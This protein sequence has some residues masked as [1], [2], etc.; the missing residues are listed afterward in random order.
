MKVLKNISVLKKAINNISSLGFVP[1]MGGLHKGHISLIKKSKKKCKKTIVSIYINPKQFDNKNDFSNY[2]RDLSKDLNLLK[3]INPDYV[4]LPTTKEMY[5]SNSNKKITLLKSEKIL[6]AK[7][8][9]G[10]FEGVLNIMD[11]FI[12]LI[13]PKYIFMGEKDFQQLYLIK[14]FIKNKY[15]S[16]IYSCKTIRDKNYI[17]LST[18]NFLL[19]KKDLIMV[20][21]ISRILKKTRQKIKKTSS[22][23]LYL[24]ILKK[25]LIKKFKIKID[26][27]ELCNEH[28]LNKSNLNKKYKIMFA[29]Y[30]K[31]IRLIDNF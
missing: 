23:L 8:R 11:R 13:K 15:K 27:L 12:S 21:K 29:F 9:K 24:N 20:G 7:I 2:P 5:K 16:K 22:P 26:Y 14:K 28:N 18:R 1:T 31:K 4:F 10:H 3:K 30:I 6:C 17:A 25:E 19:S